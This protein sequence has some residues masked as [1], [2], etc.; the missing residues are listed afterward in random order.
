MGA[1][2][3][4]TPR[5]CLA[6]A[7]PLGSTGFCDGQCCSG[8]CELDFATDEYICCACRR[9]STLYYIHSVTPYLSSGVS[10]IQL[11][12]LHLTLPAACV[13]GGQSWWPTATMTYCIWTGMQHGCCHAK[14]CLRCAALGLIVV[15]VAMHD[16]QGSLTRPICGAMAGNA[17]DRLNT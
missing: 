16:S 6:G 15:S 7:G 14:L 8:T 1:A 12:L 3:F 11:P 13:N 17:H 10:T 9:A 4:H 2:H 5:R